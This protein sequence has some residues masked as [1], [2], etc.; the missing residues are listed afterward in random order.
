MHN[1]L[2]IYSRIIF[3]LII[4]CFFFPFMDI[5]CS[6]QKF[7][8]LSG[9]QLMTGTTIKEPEL[10]NDKMDIDSQRLFKKYNI[11]IP[12]NEISKIHNID[13]EPLSIVTFSFVIFGLLFSFYKKNKYAVFPTISSSASLI[14][15]LLLK[16]KID[17]DVLREGSGAFQITY[18]IGFWSILIFLIITI[19]MNFYI[20]SIKGE[21][22]NK[23]KKSVDD[24]SLNLNL[25]TNKINNNHT[26]NTT[27]IEKRKKD[28]DT[29][30][31]HP[32]MRK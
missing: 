16:N 20:F 32:D 4:I 14:T 12:E 9:V 8:S 25:E 22:K 11:P 6:G 29:R 24:I 31:M 1:K 3:G 5:S 19:S 30:W 2:I 13:P 21:G 27:V 26:S 17:N 7:I 10:L 18:A 15:L 28:D 23:E